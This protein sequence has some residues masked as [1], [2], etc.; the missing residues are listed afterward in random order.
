MQKPDNDTLY[1]NLGRCVRGAV[2][3][4]AVGV[5]LLILASTVS[6]RPYIG[7]QQTSD[8]IHAPTVVRVSAPSGFD[9]GG[10]AIGAAAGLAI[11]LVVIGA[12]LTIAH[13]R[14]HPANT[15]SSAIG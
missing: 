8:P 4:L 5:A 12:T 7:N 3:A 6:A 10:A 1:T 13:H 11:S 9:R 15:S 14:E 2:K